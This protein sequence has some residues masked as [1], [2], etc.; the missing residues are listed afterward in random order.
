VRLSKFLS[1]SETFPME[2][3]SFREVLERVL[4]EKTPESPLN[5]S[6]EKPKPSAPH[7]NPLYNLQ[8]PKFSHARGQYPKPARRTMRAK[9]PGR[10]EVVFQLDQLTVKEREAVQYMIKMDGTFDLS[11]GLSR[12]R[13]KRAYRALAK[14]LHPDRNHSGPHSDESQPFRQLQMCYESLKQALT[15]LEAQ[16]SETAGGSESASA[17]ASQRQD[18]A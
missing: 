4:E 6:V 7:E 1:H 11:S 16:A 2:S 9:A 18:A 3:R 8:F 12:E 15:R 14:R 10:V 13:L 17:R 5:P